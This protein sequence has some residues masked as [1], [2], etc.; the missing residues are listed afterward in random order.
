MDSEL[1]R[2]STDGAQEDVR[3]LFKEAESA[4]GG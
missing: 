4:D 3:C 2:L 1:A